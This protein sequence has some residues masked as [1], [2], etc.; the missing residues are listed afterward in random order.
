VPIASFHLARYPTRLVP[1][2]VWRA[3]TQRRALRRADGMRFWKILGTG[4][5][6]TMG[7]SADL[8]RWALFA[9]WDDDAALDRFLAGS[10]VARHWAQADEAWHV[11]LRPVRAHGRWSGADVPALLDRA[12]PPPGDDEPVAVLT[13][14]RI[15]VRHLAAFHRAVPDAE[16]NL[17][18]QGG[19]LATVGIGEAPF[20]RQGTF[21]LWRSLPDVVAYAYRDDRHA[22]VVQRTR[23][24]SWYGEEL[25]A[26]FRPYHSAGTWEGV[27]PLA[28]SRTDRGTRGASIP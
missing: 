4:R 12:A 10:A 27:D 15:R 24:G 14:A 8:R 19:L 6:R 25:F 16:A 3:A 11:R 17:H 5:G 7:A 9:V 26:R 28:R 22:D 23:A 13:R 20:V 2:L 18:D 1:V 21:S